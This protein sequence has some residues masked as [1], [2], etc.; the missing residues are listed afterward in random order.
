MEFNI[1]KLETCTGHKGSVFALSE[2]PDAD[3]FFSSGEDGTI[4][5]WNLNYPDL[6]T[7]IAQMTH[8]VYAMCT[9]LEQNVLVVAQNTSGFH[10][11]DL[12]TKTEIHRIALPNVSFFDIKKVGNSIFACDSAG[13]LHKIDL[14]TYTLELS[15]RLSEKS[16][17]SISIEEN[18]RQIA[19]GFSDFKVRVFD[20][21]T[22]KLVRTIEAHTNSVFDLCYSSAGL[23]TVSRDAKIK[24]WDVKHNFLNLAEV[25]A[26]LYAINAIIK[27]KDLPFL[28]T[29][30]MDKSIKIWSETDLKLLKVINKAK[31]A[32]HGTSINRL[33]W[34]A[35]KQILLSAS[36][37]RTISIWKLF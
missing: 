31:N 23:F 25:P 36:D 27:L 37:D 18:L 6:G 7:P 13:F 19:I 26:H 4:V 10:F 29:C 1:Q 30:S 12:N 34:L 11:I 28:V 33:L 17:R 21:D 32:G 9:L 8:S 16:A 22:F 3:T 24:L 2:G 35:Q 14:S 15:L 20:L 5:L